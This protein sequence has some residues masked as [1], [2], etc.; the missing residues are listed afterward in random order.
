MVEQGQE[1]AGES[2]PA[3]RIGLGRAGGP[4]VSAGVEAEDAVI[5]QG[6]RQVEPELTV[7]VAARG[8]AVE[9]HDQGP[10]GPVDVERERGT[11][12]GECLHATSHSVVYRPSAGTPARAP[13]PGHRRA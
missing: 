3:I 13:V 7:T 4:A 8:E 9:L 10:A 12:R 11:A 6:T 2:I 1:V 5:A